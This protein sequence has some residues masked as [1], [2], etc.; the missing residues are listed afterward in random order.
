MI[1][2]TLINGINFSHCKFR[3]YEQFKRSLSSNENIIFLKREYGIGGL[4]S[5]YYGVDFGQEY[6]SKGIRLYKG[7]K[8]DRP[9][10]LI[11]WN[12]VEQRLK[13]LIRLDRYFNTE[14]KEKY[15]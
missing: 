11:T 15:Q 7:F 5:A 10:L 12:K 3:I 9:E 6:D 14:E 13:E 1:D 8:D 2:N 4:S